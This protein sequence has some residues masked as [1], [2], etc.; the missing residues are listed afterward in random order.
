MK[1]PKAYR[2]IHPWFAPGSLRGWAV[3]DIVNP[4]G[5]AAALLMDRGIIELIED[6]P[7]PKDE[8]EFAEIETAAMDLAEQVTPREPVKRKRKKK[9]VHQ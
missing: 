4:T 9:A 7:D 3:G 2:V 6:E 5:G 8:M 1:T